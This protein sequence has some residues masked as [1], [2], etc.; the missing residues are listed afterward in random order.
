MA[1]TEK[2]HIQI[3]NKIIFE[4]AYEIEELLSK[5]DF[6][7]CKIGGIRIQDISDISLKTATEW[8]KREILPEI[9]NTEL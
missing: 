5:N 8:F 7:L 9:N 6:F 3:I 1:L 4:K 2:K